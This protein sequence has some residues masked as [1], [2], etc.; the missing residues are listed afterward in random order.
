MRLLLPLLFKIKA[1]KSTKLVYMDLFPIAEWL[2]VNS[3]IAEYIR[4]NTSADIRIFN[5]MAPSHN[6]RDL[7]KSYGLTQIEIIRLSTGQVFHLGRLFMRVLKEVKS[8]E[9]LFRLE[10]AGIRIGIDIYESILRTGVPTVKINSMDTRRKVYLA[11]RQYIFFHNKLS[12]N[13][14]HSFILSHDSY[15]GP[16]I[17]GRMAHHFQVPVIQANIFEINILQRPFQNY[18]RFLRYREYFGSLDPATQSS[19]LQLG[20]ENIERRLGGE[21]NIERDGRLIS[22]LDA[23]RRFPRQVRSSLKSKIL[24]LTHDFFDNPHAYSV[25]PFIDFMEWLEF[26]ATIASETDYDWYIK[27]HPDS[28]GNEQRVVEEFTKTYPVFKMVDPLTSLQQLVQEGISFATTC[29]GTVGSEL[30]LMG[31]NVINAAYNPH[32]AYSFN[33]HAQNLEDYKYILENLN[34]LDFPRPSIDEICEFA[35]VHRFMMSPDDF[36]LPSVRDYL[37]KTDSDPLGLVAKKYIWEVRSIIAQ[38]I[39]SEFQDAL[40]D[41]RVF[42]VEKCLKS[43]LQ[44][45]ISKGGNYQDFFASFNL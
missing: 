30:P 25:L 35:Y 18:E 26:L 27:C 20:R 28:S 4:E 38:K 14:I 13:Q 15:I 37:A 3:A 10:I 1:T 24:V 19:A 23:T 12:R 36:S 29:Y 39:Q 8:P 40:V 45:K 7:T 21:V 9:D 6:S 41:S 42:S 22:S 11:L 43:E 33:T 2:A 44:S 34:L 5:F 16:G 17:C 32:I 31:V